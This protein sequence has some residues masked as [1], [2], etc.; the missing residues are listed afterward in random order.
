[1]IPSSTYRLQIQRDFTLDDATSIVGYLRE[2]GAGA[3]YLSPVLQSTS[4][5]EHGYD[6]VDPSQIDRD[7]GGSAGLARLI[8][9]ARD[10]G[11][12][13]VIDIVPNHLGISAPVEN[14]AWWDVLRLGPD[15]AYAN[16]FDIDWSRDR[17]VLPMLGDDPVFDARRRRVAVF[18]APVPAGSGQL[19]RR[20]RPGRRA[21]SAALRARPSLPRQH[22]AEL[23][24]LLRRDHA[25]RGAGRGPRGLRGYPRA[26]PASGR[27]PGSPG[28]GST[29]R[30]GWSTRRSTWSGCARSLRTSGSPWRRSWRPANTCPPTGRSPAPPATTPCARSTAS[31]S[32]RTPS[33]RSPSSTSG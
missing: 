26:G 5:S 30:T 3:V 32:I 24:A 16:W 9:A 25:G 21:R 10:A 4:G 28:C 22:R 33:P 14:P 1:M 11:L 12:G 23:P 2:L 19:G 29:T 7:R 18:R 15:S 20:R 13:V 6:T 31:S 17:I 27:P 8:E